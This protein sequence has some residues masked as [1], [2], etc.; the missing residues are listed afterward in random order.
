MNV[1]L[2]AM[3]GA[4]VSR[5]SGAEEVVIAQ[6]HSL[7]QDEQLAQTIGYFHTVLP[8]VYVAEAAQGSAHAFRAMH[9]QFVQ[10]LQH[11][12]AVAFQGQKWPFG[13]TSG[14]VAFRPQ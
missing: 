7:R 1:G 13:Q 11:S 6:P 3:W 5:L 9:S 2:L 4:Y 10:A 12:Q 8:L 14:A